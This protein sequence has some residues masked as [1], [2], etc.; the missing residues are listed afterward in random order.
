[1]RVGCSPSQS[2]Y[3][4]SATTKE[5]RGRRL[6]VAHINPTPR[7][8]SRKTRQDKTRQGGGQ[9]GAVLWCDNHLRAAASSHHGFCV[10]GGGATGVQITDGVT[11]LSN[12]THL[13][14]TMQAYG[15]VEA[16]HMGR[17]GLE[18]AFVRYQHASSAEKAV[19]ALEK[20]LV[21]MDGVQLKGGY[22]S[23]APRPSPDYRSMAD[24]VAAAR[25]RR[26]N[27]SR[28]RDRDR[29]RDRDRRSSRSRGKG[30]RDRERDRDRDDDKDRGGG[31]R[32]RDRSRP[33]VLRVKL[34][35][36]NSS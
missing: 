12:R 2:V 31:R 27:R 26:R 17:R 13:K 22:H 23:T 16:V 30:S 34:A 9:E 20:G 8:P 4:R 10:P 33:V 3:R 11:E 24:E 5:N 19:E 25:D 18:P 32:D 36:M 1:M 7:P 14:S 29:D 21:F 15:L 35:C 28:S 6:A